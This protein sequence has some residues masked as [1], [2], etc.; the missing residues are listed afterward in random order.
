MNIFEIE[1]LPGIEE[2]EIVD[3]L[4]ENEDVK[5]ERIIS[6]GQVSDWMVQE[7]R[8]YV[9]LIQGNAVIEFNDKTVEMK[10]GDTLFIEK[11]ERHRV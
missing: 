8:E 3:I 11:R 10:S 2:E 1:K 7:K 4:K 6:T 9:L 5:I